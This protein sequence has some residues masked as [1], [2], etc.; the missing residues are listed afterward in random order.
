[1]PPETPFEIAGRPIG[2]GHP[3]YVI[4]EL[5][6][7]H[8]GD[9]DR[10]RAIMTAAKESGADAVKLQTYT[11]DTL[12]IDCDRPEFRLSDGPWAGRTLHDLYREA[13]TPWN[14]HAD[15]FQIGADLGLAVFST[16]FRS[17]RHRAAGIAP[18]AGIQDRQF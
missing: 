4:A 11:A 9:L 6:A 5:S 7:N 12:T 16:P 1:M 14:F 15:L 8:G 10:A 2:R 17:D 18:R 13:H 3:P